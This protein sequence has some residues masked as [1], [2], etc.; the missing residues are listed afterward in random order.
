MN[1]LKKQNNHRLLAKLML[2]VMLVTVIFPLSSAYFQENHGKV[3]AAVPI[4]GL[5]IQAVRNNYSLHQGGKAVDGAYGNF[6]PY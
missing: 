4:D 6:G 1:I 3:F 5:A 2:I